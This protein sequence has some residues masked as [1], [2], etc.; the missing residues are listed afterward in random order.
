M[1]RPATFFSIQAL[2]GI[3][4]LMVVLFHLRI[5]EGK[6]GQDG[7]LLGAM[8]AYADSGVDLFF[9]LSGFVMTSI[10]AGSYGLPRNAGDFLARRGWRVLPLYWF[11]TTLVV[12][13]MLLMP[14]M[15]NSAYQDQSILASYLLW[16]QAQLPLLTVGWTLIHEAFF[17]LLMAVAIA[18]AR[19]RQ[20]P[21]LLLGWAAATLLAHGM[22]GAGIAPWAAVASSPLSLEF[23]AG[24]LIG[25]YWRRLPV[26]FA[27]PL[28]LGGAVLLVAAMLHLA[29]AYPEHPPVLR[30]ALLFGV[31]AA[32]LVLG[33]V[34]WEH[35]R[36]PRLPALLLAVGDSSY[37]LYLGH[38]FVISATGRL[39]QASGL[40]HAPWQ[41]ALF[42]A[43]T[44]VVCVIAGWLS[45]RWLELPLHRW[46]RTRKPSA[47]TLQAAQE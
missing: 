20:L 3:A 16:P 14:G 15:A 25:L 33:A 4:A 39:W 37:S 6:Y 13:L 9:V 45:W 42:I 47:R 2:R 36:Q 8:F 26:G 18:F 21:W 43:L 7:N 46:T 10:A 31:P 34:R 11:Y 12:A 5:V 23:I 24:G 1:T 30:R 27:L 22:L 32:L 41:H 19:E 29:A 17:Y 40:N 28:L 44:V 35:A 38:V